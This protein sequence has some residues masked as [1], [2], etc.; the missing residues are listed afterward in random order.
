MREA[1][2]QQVLLHWN[3]TPSS[4]EPIIDHGLTGLGKILESPLISAGMTGEVI[5]SLLLLRGYVL[6]HYLAFTGKNEFTTTEGYPRKDVILPERGAYAHTPCFSMDLP[7]TYFIQALFTTHHATKILKLKPIAG[8]AST[9]SFKK[10]FRGATVRFTGFERA[11]DD[12]AVSA[13]G[14]RAAYIRGFGI[15]GHQTQKGLDFLL[16]VRLKSR[17]SSSGKDRFTFLGIQVKNRMDEMPMRDLVFEAG[18]YGIFGNSTKR[19]PYLVLGMQLGVRP[20]SVRGEEGAVIVLKWLRGG[21]TIGKTSAKA[22]KSSLATMA[23]PTTPPAQIIGSTVARRTGRSEDLDA[24]PHDHP[25]Y[26]ASAIGCTEQLYKVITKDERDSFA[27]ILSRRDIYHEHSRLGI[28]KEL[29]KYTAPERTMGTQSYG[30]VNEPLL[31][32]HVAEEEE[33][34]D[35]DDD[36]DDNDDNEDDDYESNSDPEEETLPECPRSPLTSVRLR[37]QAP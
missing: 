10:A 15:I 24:N 27:K 3:P 7:V 1:L 32:G 33:S 21:K 8:G 16:P 23:L 36:N 22:K 18:G 12:I 30:W 17:R 9:R 37:T 6:G 20:K 34:E 29:L 4:T 19:E 13:E 11:A 14:L 28:Y 5:A 2:L 26:F 31:H 25:F 35:E